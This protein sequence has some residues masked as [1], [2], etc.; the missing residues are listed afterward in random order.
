MFAQFVC[1]S[2]NNFTQLFE[3]SAH[4]CKGSRQQ[5]IPRYNQASSQHVRRL[6]ALFTREGHLFFSYEIDKKNFDPVA[7][8]EFP[9]GRC[10]I[11]Y[12]SN[13]LPNPSIE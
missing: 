4:Q 8:P 7:D 3:M 9:M 6:V 1:F 10:A 13:N 12:F 5:G 11:L 2:F